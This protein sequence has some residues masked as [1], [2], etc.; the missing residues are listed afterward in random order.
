MKLARDY[1]GP[2]GMGEYGVGWWGMAGNDP[3]DVS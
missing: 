1:G 2:P 3:S